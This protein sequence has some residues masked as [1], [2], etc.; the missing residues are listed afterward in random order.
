LAGKTD[1]QMGTQV[2]RQSG[3]HANRERGVRGEGERE[4]DRDRETEGKLDTERE[5]WRCT[6]KH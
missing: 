2:G 3:R 4:R 6:L 1:R 5:I